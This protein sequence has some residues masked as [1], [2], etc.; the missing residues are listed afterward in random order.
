MVTSPASGAA[1]LAVTLTATCP[2][3]SYTWDFGDGQTATGQTVHHVY[4]AG[5]WHP[6]L[7]TDAGAEP[8]QPVTSI[9]L[10]LRGP[11]RARYAQWVVLHATVVPRLP[12]T[13]RGRKFVGGVL[14]V[15]VLGTTPWV[16]EA[17]GVKSNAV[18]TRVT[19]KLVVRVAGT[20]VV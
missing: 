12:V 3:A 4:T 13:L 9:A 18:R 14:R 7:T 16:A 2:S 20:P 6:T 1:P 11:A 5:Y 17:N 10:T 19:P 15:R 8:V